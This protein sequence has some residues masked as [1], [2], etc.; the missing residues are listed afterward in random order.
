[1]PTEQVKSATHRLEQ[2]ALQTKPIAEDV[3]EA[4]GKR[5]VREEGSRNHAYHRFSSTVN[6]W[7][8]SVKWHR[9]RK[10]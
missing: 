6:Q 2:K 10:I 7:N 9:W 1:M 4:F 8:N 3:Q 5:E